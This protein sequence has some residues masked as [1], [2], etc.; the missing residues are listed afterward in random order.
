MK[1]IVLIACSLLTIGGCSGL[2]EPSPSRARNEGWATI[3]LPNTSRADAFE[4]GQYA[5][6]QWFRIE[7]V[8]PVDG[9]IRSAMAEYDQ[10]GGTE[11]IRDAVK[12]KNRMRRSAS[13][14]VQEQGTDCIARCIVRV[15][16]LDTADHR[17]YRDT[18]QFV[19][20]P[21]ETPIDRDAGITAEQDQVWTDMPRDRRLETDILNV[22]RSKLGKPTSS[23]SPSSDSRS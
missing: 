12:T 1:K 6:K 10:R 5:M 16:R 11:R 17:I 19:D 15:Q 3:R 13:L 2:E 22:L 7:Q 14:Y 4:A 21:N 20:Y 23:S 8:S 18:N 9:Q